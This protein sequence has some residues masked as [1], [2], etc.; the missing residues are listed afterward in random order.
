MSGGKFQ[1]KKSLGQHFLRNDVVPKWLCDAGRVA[2]GDIVFEI[3]PGTGALTRELLMRGARVI[4]LEADARAITVLEEEFAAELATGQLC[5][6]HGDARTIDFITLGLTDHSYK[7]IANIP[8]YLSGHLFRTMLESAV[9]PTDLVFLVQKEV[10]ERIARAEKESLLS[11]SVKVY[12]DPTYVKTVSRGHFTPPPEVDSAIVAVTNISR[13]HLANVDAT[14]FFTILHLGF[15][16]KRK[17]LLGNLAKQY[18][19]TQLTHIFSTL[20]LPIDIRA[21]DVSLNM[22]LKLVETLSDS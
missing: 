20:T 14:H 17:Q 8:Y 22:W 7:C 12:G 16:Q 3:G 13:N 10:A 4:A 5:L 11:L 1:H 2:P 15:A 9:Q 21:E 18:D 19:R 6:H